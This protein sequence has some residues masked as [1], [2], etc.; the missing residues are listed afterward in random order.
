MRRLP[1]VKSA[2]TVL[3][4][5]LNV[6]PGEE[7]LIV[8]DT[9]QLAIAELF[10]ILGQERGAETMVLIMTPR[11]RHGEE[12]PRVVAAAMKA[13]DACLAPTTF[14]VNHTRARA[15][16]SAAGM[17]LIFM[18]G[19]SEE[20]FTSGSLEVDYK[21]NAKVIEKM[22]ALLTE[23]SMAHVTSPEGTD[24]WVEI[25]GRKSVAQTGIVDAPGK[26]SPPP[27]IECAIAPLEEKTNG[28]W[29]IDGAIVPPGGM[30]TEPVR[31]Y[32]E[33]GRITRI[34]GGPSAKRLRD[35]LDSYNDP[36]MY[37]PVELGVGL[38]PKAKCGRGISIEDEAEFGT[39]HVGIG[40]G[41]TFG[42]SIR[43]VGHVDLVILNPVLELDER[44]VLKD[45]QV[46]I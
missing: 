31:V 43:A 21:A 1:W 13:A 5:C 22:A 3:D 9:N 36:N 30:V 16:A 4:D 24:L 20:V 41:I 6:K 42:S 19:V 32:F 11:S 29:V 8:T 44:V 25:A 35:L 26:I 28:V 45:R 15:E 39:M 33:K 34:E 14:S 17:R 23:A 46:L 38:N 12:L 2:K 27:C 40:N 18:P 37:C 10:S 7:L